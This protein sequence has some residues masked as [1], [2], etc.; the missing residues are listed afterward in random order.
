MELEELRNEYRKM[1]NDGILA[2]A[3]GTKCANCGSTNNIEFHHIVPLFLGGSNNLRNIVP[4]CNRCHKVAHMGRHMSHYQNLKRSGRK[5]NVADD[6][7]FAALDKWADGQIG[8]KKCA[9][10]IG[11]K[12]SDNRGISIHDLIQ[13]KKWCGIHGYKHVKNILDAKVTNGSTVID[14]NTFVVFIDH[15]GSPYYRLPEEVLF[16]DTGENDDVL[17]KVRGADR[18]EKFSEIQKKRKGE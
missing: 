3:L 2:K 5:P 17:Y 8:N 9:E 1:R 18:Y 11:M 6:E 4:L 16:H 12:C 14:E 15:I 13:Y 10:L 7:A